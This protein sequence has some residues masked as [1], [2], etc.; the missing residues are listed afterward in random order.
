MTTDP[1]AIDL[2]GNLT[3][4]PIVQKRTDNVL[5]EFEG[6]QPKY[7]LFKI[8]QGGRLDVDPELV[9]VGD[10]VRVETVYS[11]IGVHHTRDKHDQLIRQQILEAIH[12]EITPFVEGEDDGIL[13]SARRGN[14]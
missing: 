3:R 10:R 13:R 8:V 9:R 5:P 7:L 1:G 6:E 4:D 2:S 11:C 14:D 12:Q